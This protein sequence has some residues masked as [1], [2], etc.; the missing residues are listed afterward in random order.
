MKQIIDWLA[1]NPIKAQALKQLLTGVVF[2]VAQ[3]TLYQNAPTQADVGLYVALVMTVLGGD[4][5]ALTRK[6]VES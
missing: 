2:W 3:W 4:T 5:A 1:A 6:G